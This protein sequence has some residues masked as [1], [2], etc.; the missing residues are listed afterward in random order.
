VGGGWVHTNAQN[1]FVGKVSI[2]GGRGDLSVLGLASY[3]KEFS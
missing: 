3:R 2:G 1:F